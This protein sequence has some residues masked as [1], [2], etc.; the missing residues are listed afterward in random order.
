MGG[1]FDSLGSFLGL[2]L[3]VLSLDSLEL[4]NVL[5][6]VLVLLKSDEKL[7]LLLLT[8]LLSLHSDGLSLDLLEDSVVVSAERYTI[9]MSQIGSL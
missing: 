5:V 4:S 6:E 9:K 3:L 2:V 8:V 7:G 1:G